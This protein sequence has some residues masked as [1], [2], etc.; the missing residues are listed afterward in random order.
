METACWT[1][2]CASD[3]QATAAGLQ[4]V[5]RN[6]FTAVGNAI[7]VALQRGETERA[8]GAR[9]LSAAAVAGAGTGAVPGSGAVPGTALL[10]APAAPPP[11]VTVPEILQT[12]TPP[13]ALTDAEVVD[14]LG[15]AERLG[16]LLTRSLGLAHDAA[17][18]PWTE[19]EVLILI[20]TEWVPAVA[21]E[22]NHVITGRCDREPLYLA[23]PHC[24]RP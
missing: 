8:A 10:T 1:A 22:R 20:V 2:T 4:L 15:G 9:A 11:V 24:R 6:P 16:G 21:W 18:M 7:F 23:P 3:A 14:K 13:H 12:I 19:P 5:G 17:F